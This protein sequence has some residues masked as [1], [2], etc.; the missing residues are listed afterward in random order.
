MSNSGF[1]GMTFLF[2]IR[3]LLSPRKKVLKEVGIRPGHRVLDFGCGPGGYILPTADLVGDKGRIY[4]L[5][6]HPKAL[7]RVEGIARKAGLENVRTIGSSCE[8]GLDDAS[9][10]VVL[11]HDVYHDL[12]RPYEVLKELHRVLKQD[13]ILS[14]SDHHVKDEDI[15][16]GVTGSGLFRLSSRG[17]KTFTFVKKGRGK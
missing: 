5:D 3:D 4:A 9:I 6:I 12:K 13:G 2:S 11:L 7:E 15:I 17:R 8:T 14:F 16:E 1:S 10:D